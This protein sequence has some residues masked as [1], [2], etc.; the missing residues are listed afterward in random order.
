M[1][2]PSEFEHIFK[3]YY[4]QLFCFA[5]QMIN[6]EQECYDIVNEAYENVWRN[7]ENIYVETARAYLYA[8]VRN[9]CINNLRRNQI[10]RQYIEYY[11]KVTEPYANGEELAEMLEKERIIREV[12]EEM[13]PP[14]RDI[15]KACLFNGKKYKEVAEDMGISLSLVK[16]HM[17]K[18]MTIIK[19]N[20]LKKFKTG[21]F[22]LTQM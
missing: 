15:V 9:K 4:A 20:V 6:N 19:A 17:V 5:R 18:A 10:H 7:R 12:I 2:K 16:K 21:T 13:Q 3:A 1:D 11:I 8:C 22:I 14:V